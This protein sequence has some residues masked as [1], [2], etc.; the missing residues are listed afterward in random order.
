MNERRGVNRLLRVLSSRGSTDRPRSRWASFL[1]SRFETM[2]GELII[3]LKYLCAAGDFVSGH[4]FP[5]LLCSFL[6]WHTRVLG[7]CGVSLID[8][9]ESRAEWA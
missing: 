5:L 6:V 8:R 7:S 1:R 2:C 4:N 3:Y 9:I